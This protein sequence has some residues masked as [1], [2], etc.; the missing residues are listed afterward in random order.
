MRILDFSD[1]LFDR[2]SFTSHLAQMAIE[3][4]ASPLSLS[5]EKE[6]EETGSGSHASTVAPAG[7]CESQWIPAGLDGVTRSTLKSGAIIC[8][9][10]LGKP[11]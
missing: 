6:R 3:R 9:A 11:S 8:H 7:P 5:L 2:S 4:V 1:S 10:P